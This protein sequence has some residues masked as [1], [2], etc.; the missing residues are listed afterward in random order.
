MAF[1]DD[2]KRANSTGQQLDVFDTFVPESI[3]RTESTGLIVSS[4]AVLN[5]NLHERL[6]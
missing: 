6:L 2:L 4:L 3:S 1:D 5:L